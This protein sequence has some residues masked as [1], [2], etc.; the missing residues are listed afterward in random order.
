[1]SIMTT[2]MSRSVRNHKI[3]FL[4]QEHL[5]CA[6]MCKNIYYRKPDLLFNKHKN[7]LYI[8]IEGSDTI[9]NWIDNISIAMKRNDV[10]RGFARYASYC[11]N[12]YDILDLVDDFDAYDKIILTG[13]SLGSASATLIARELC[14]SYE[15]RGARF[16]SKFELVLF[17]CPKIGG[18]SFK[19]E[20]NDLVDKTGLTIYSYENKKDI[21]CKIPFGFLG[22]T[23]T[24]LQEDT[25]H[26][27]PAT[28]THVLDIYT[29]H[30]MNQYI[31]SLQESNYT[32]KNEN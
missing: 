13:H 24:F 27:E 20:F 6:H 31:E 32:K 7:K 17:G 19:K 25:V 1:M 10:H 18:N 15:K 8:S 26:L 16:H 22:Y 2:M 30:S 29:N 12:E 21:V 9:I 11:M 14:K 28:N 4:N 23:H 3:T 5:H